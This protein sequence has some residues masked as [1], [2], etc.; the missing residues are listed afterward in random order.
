MTT[1]ERTW[2][3]ALREVF[4]SAARHKVISALIAACVVA[5][6]TVIAVIGTASHAVGANANGGLNAEGVGAIIP[7]GQP[8]APSF[9]F[10]ELGHPG[11]RVAL[12][13]YTGKPLIV[14]FFA[15]WCPPCKLETP[16]LASFYR[17][18][19]GSV[20]LVGM[21]ENDTTGNA[22]SFAKANRVTYPLAWDP[23]IV[24][25]NAYDVAGMPQT[26]FL[27]ARHRIVY[28]VI[29]QITTAELHQGIALATG[30][31]S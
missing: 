24:A 23:N 12:D 2:S 10:P 9:S 11:Q 18:E 15:S 13:D 7:A 16:M 8:A 31:P 1:Q 4:R 3:S 14:N 20:P 29:G 28:H 30:T 25:G 22:L 17:T 26:F 5:T 27:N 19:H 6:F 21:D